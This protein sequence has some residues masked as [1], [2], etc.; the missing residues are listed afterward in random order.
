MEDGCE[1]KVV[2]IARIDR[3]LRIRVSKRNGERS[4]RRMLRSREAFF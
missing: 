4:S 3:I 2:L 1:V